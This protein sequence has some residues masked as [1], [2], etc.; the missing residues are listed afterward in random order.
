MGREIDCGHVV[1]QVEGVVHLEGKSLVES[2]VVAREYST[3]PTT[4]NGRG[5]ATSTF[6]LNNTLYD[7]PEPITG[8]RS[9]GVFQTAATQS[10]GLV[11]DARFVQN[12]DFINSGQGFSEQLPQNPRIAPNVFVPTP[13]YGLDVPIATASQIGDFLVSTQLASFH[14]PV[15]QWASMTDMVPMPPNMANYGDFEDTFR[16]GIDMS[17]TTMIAPFDPNIDTA[18]V[19]FGWTGIE[20]LED[21]DNMTTDY[22]MMSN[23][24]AP[25][26]NTLQQVAPSIPQALP[27]P[28][29]APGPRATCTYCPQTFARDY[30]RIRHENSKHLRPANANM[31]P[32]AGCQKNRGQGFSRPDKLTEHM[33]KK[34]GNLGY[35]KRV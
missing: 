2:G 12:D 23:P 21:L 33:W 22:P 27:A 10:Q 34:H 9:I 1:C 26:D 25:G 4:K 29:Q 5:P 28:A 30:D 31:C 15:P 24:T 32:I 20:D 16:S 6:T 17:N 3:E 35:T 14:Q 19:N 11:Y 7:L 13:N 18:A 8:Q